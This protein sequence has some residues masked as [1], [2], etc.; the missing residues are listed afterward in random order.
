MAPTL[1]Y[2]ALPG[3]A[4]VSRLLFTLGGKEF[5]VKSN[6]HA[7]KDCLSSP[8]LLARSAV[9]IRSKAEHFWMWSQDKRITQDEWRELKGSTPF[10]QVPI[11]DVDGKRLAQSA[12]IGECGCCATCDTTIT[13]RML[14][15]WCLL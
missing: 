6:M 4:E 12:A 5:Q 1:T 3:R 7:A 2:F 13:S 15:C 10:G 8:Q 14:L 9:P 11:L